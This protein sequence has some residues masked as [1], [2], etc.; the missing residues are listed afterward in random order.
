MKVM[1]VKSE[2]DTESQEIINAQATL[3]E[4]FEEALR[5]DLDGYYDDEGVEP[6]DHLGN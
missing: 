1:T 6:E 2:D 3:F 5:G 4:L